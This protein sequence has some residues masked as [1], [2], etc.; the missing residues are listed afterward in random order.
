MAVSVICI[1]GLLKVIYMQIEQAFWA[2]RVLDTFFHNTFV[3]SFKYSA[4]LSI[5]YLQ[6]Y[7]KDF[8]VFANTVY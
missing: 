8:I 6:L 2:N 1:R 3:S 7:I 4:G 5:V